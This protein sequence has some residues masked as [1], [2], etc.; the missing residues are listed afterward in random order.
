MPNEKLKNYSLGQLDRY[1]SLKHNIYITDPT[2]VDVDDAD[3]V[4]AHNVYSENHDD[5][6][7]L[8][9]PLLN[10]NIPCLKVKTT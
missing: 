10:V 3:A 2:P 4:H 6:P 1:V 5:P 7:T 8:I 9:P